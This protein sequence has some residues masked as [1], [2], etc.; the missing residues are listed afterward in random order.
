M[1]ETPKMRMEQVG[2]QW[3]VYFGGRFYGWVGRSSDPAPWDATSAADT[4]RQGD[5]WWW[6]SARP[7]S[8]DTPDRGSGHTRRDAAASMLR[9]GPE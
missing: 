5:R 1:S 8:E 3:R 4:T 7:L 6:T 9:L 2:Q